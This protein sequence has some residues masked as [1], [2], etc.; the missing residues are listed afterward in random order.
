VNLHV[1]NDTYGLYPLEIAKRIKSGPKGNA[2]VNLCKAAKHQDGIITYIP[3][4][5]SGF[6]N[7]LRQFNHLDKLIFHPYQ[8]NSY[9]I[10]KIVKRKF[11]Q[12]KVYWA[13]WSSE[14]YCQPPLPPGYYGPFSKKFVKNRSSFRERIKDTKIIGPLILKL[15][16]FLRLKKNHSKR[17]KKSFSQIDF[18]CSL[19]PSD[20]AYFQKISGSTK[21]VHLPFAYLSIENIVAELPEIYSTGD[22]VMIGHSA[23]PAGNHFEILTRLHKLDAKLS[24]FLPLVYGVT[25]YGDIIQSE[26][27]KRFPHAEILRKELEKSLYYQK[28]AEVAWAIINVKVQQALGNITALIWMGVKVFLDEQSS[29]FKDFKNWGIAIFS[30][31]KDLSLQELTQ[32]LTNA[33]ISEN[34]RIIFEKCNE[35]AVK[36]YWEPILN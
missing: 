25:S 27:I 3:F 9:I 4:S 13:L 31:Q 10:L 15:S 28:L 6:E 14:L 16:Y 20:F 5:T 19:L 23:S 1:T 11:P 17:W 36:N 32:K 26:A 7:Y 12:I 18:F 2:I 21:T 24:I 29:T 35:N 34:R 33:E 8:Y 30:I 22:K